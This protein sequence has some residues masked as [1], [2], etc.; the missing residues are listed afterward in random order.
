MLKNKLNQIQ[1]IPFNIVIIDFPD[2]GNYYETPLAK[3]CMDSWKKVFPN[4]IYKK[5]IITK[6]EIQN[7]N[8]FYIQ[9]FEK[10]KG[11]GINLKLR[12]SDIFRLIKLNENNNAIYMD[13]DV[14]LDEDFINYFVSYIYG[15][16]CYFVGKM[17][18]TFIWNKKKNNPII[19]NILEYFDLY[20]LNK[21]N[22]SFDID[23]DILESILREIQIPEL[24]YLIDESSSYFSHIY[25]QTL[26]PT[27]SHPYINDC[28]NF[29][30][31]IKNFK[32][33]IIKKEYFE[34]LEDLI[35]NRKFKT[36]YIEDKKDIKECIEYK[37]KK[38]EKDFFNISSLENFP[39]KANLHN[40]KENKKDN[41]F[42]FLTCPKYIDSKLK[43]K[44]DIIL[45]IA[46]V[47]CNKDVYWLKNLMVSILEKIKGMPLYQISIWDNTT[48]GTAKNICKELQNKYSNTIHYYTDNKNLYQFEGRKRIIQNS[49]SDYIWF[50]DC[51]DNILNIPKGFED[52]GVTQYEY[53]LNSNPIKLKKELKIYTKEDLEKVKILD[54][55]T[56]WN[57]VIKTNILKYVVENFIPDTPIVA[58]YM[59]DNFY[60]LA[61]IETIVNTTY[62]PISYKKQCIYNH[63][64]TSKSSSF[65]DKPNVNTFF[66]ENL[67][68]S[69]YLINLFYLISLIYVDFNFQIFLLSL[70]KFFYKGLE[71]ID[72]SK[73]NLY[74]E[75][76]KIIF[77]PSYSYLLQI[78]KDTSEF[79]DIK[80]YFRLEDPIKKSEFMKAVKKREFL[81]HKKELIKKFPAILNGKS[82][83]E[84]LQELLK[85]AFPIEEPKN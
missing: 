48:E 47:T 68:G 63:R 69:S 78:Q 15:Q 61:S 37:F 31:D 64:S 62:L 32:N 65:V 74:L 46:I 14:F 27:I 24:R 75:D 28:D 50:V 41:S 42:L 85:Q 83:D 58:S 72:S 34:E 36:L 70:F 5:Y 52:S 35:T 84:F 54:T 4:A 56:L 57:K 26:I 60:Y 16:P 23:K 73:K 30:I 51:D 55:W 19:D 21:K 40:L 18:G 1:Q 33:E 80:D 10:Y 44:K 29:F 2:N 3:R 67:K 17:L 12:Y 11:T 45:E 8:S 49:N 7:Q 53:Q 38:E 6:E 71:D 66:N 20:F 22:P 59:E 82:E 81:I 76:L 9:H 79:I 39:D 43:S 13:S 77:G 25:G